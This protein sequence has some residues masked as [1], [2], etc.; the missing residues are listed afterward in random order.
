MRKLTIVQNANCSKPA[1]RSIFA[2]NG[3][4]RGAKIIGICTRTGFSFF[5][6]VNEVFDNYILPNWCDL[7][8]S[9]FNV[10][11][12]VFMFKSST[13]T[14]I[15]GFSHPFFVCDFCKICQ[16]AVTVA[17]AKHKSPNML[18]KS[19]VV[20]FTRSTTSAQALSCPCQ[21]WKRILTN[22]LHCILMCITCRKDNCKALLSNFQARAEVQGKGTVA[23][24]VC[25]KS[26]REMHSSVA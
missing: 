10:Y 15:K 1:Y 16:E 26:A 25:A 12:M 7:S 24:H 21:L 4:M 3:E 22:L 6:I 20:F 5:P 8:F 2:S 18:F 13:G 11:N 23:W 19:W 17:E 9:Q 14:V